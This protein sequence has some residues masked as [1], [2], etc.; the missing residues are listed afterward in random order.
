MVDATPKFK[1]VTGIEAGALFFGISER[2]SRYLFM[3]CQ[4]DVAKVTPAMVVKRVKEIL[5]HDGL[6]A[7]EAK[8]AVKLAA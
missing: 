6:T 1:D 8:H 5:K 2:A 4:Y 3:P 7:D